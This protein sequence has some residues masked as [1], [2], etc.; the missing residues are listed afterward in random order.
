MCNAEYSQHF[1]SNATGQTHNGG[2]PH[3]NDQLATMLITKI[4]GSH[5]TFIDVGAHIGSII[6]EVHHNDPSTK[7]V[8]IKAIPQK[9]KKFA[10][11]IS[12]R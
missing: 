1:N 10:A 6:A 2:R 3:A 4:C 12:I 8:A 11:E 7:I 9:V 5:K